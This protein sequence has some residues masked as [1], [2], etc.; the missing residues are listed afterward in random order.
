MLQHEHLG[1]LKVFV[2]SKTRGKPKYLTQGEIR[3]LFS[4]HT[5]NIKLSFTATGYTLK[6]IL[7]SK[8]IL[9]FPIK[10]ICDWKVLSVYMF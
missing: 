3:L 10:S 2:Q 6:M 5:S 4:H 1:E 8:G 9:M 7:I